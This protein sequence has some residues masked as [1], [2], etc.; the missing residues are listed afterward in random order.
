MLGWLDENKPNILFTYNYGLNVRA[1]APA[2]LTES[3]VSFLRKKLNLN[4]NFES[5]VKSDKGDYTMG[6]KFDD[7]KYEI[8]KSQVWE[9]SPTEPYPMIGMK[10]KLNSNG[11]EITFVSFRTQVGAFLYKKTEVERKLTE[12]I[13]I[14]ES[15]K[16]YII[17]SIDAI[18]YKRLSVDFP[19]DPVFEGD[20]Q[21][22]NDISE[23]DSDQEWITTTQQY[24]ILHARA[25]VFYKAVE[26][27]PS[28]E[29]FEIMK[30]YEEEVDKDLESKL[31]RKEEALVGFVQIIDAVDMKF[32]KR[33]I[34][35]EIDE[36]ISKIPDFDA[37]L[38]EDQIYEDSEE[39]LFQSILGGSAWSTDDIL[40]LAKKKRKIQINKIMKLIEE[41]YDEQIKELSIL[42]E[43]IKAF[44]AEDKDTIENS[45]QPTL[46][47][48]NDLKTRIREIIKYLMNP[49]FKWEKGF[50]EDELLQ[51]KIQSY[52]SHTRPLSQRSRQ[53]LSLIHI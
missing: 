20:T 53:N 14:L 35:A 30:K 10:I 16:E 43:T 52:L 5:S 8:S 47:D 39:E 21:R 36:A 26:G 34:S 25:S 24:K 48:L 41:R 49:K 9:G 22:W 11:K 46:D 3:R 45:E 18:D 51:A 17:I 31:S 38:K 33:Q 4:G 1:T 37:L 19:W 13:G 6:V 44:S 32:S 42:S 27:K 7:T 50:S 15:N 12:M 29:I 2:A 28:G 40:D 23:R